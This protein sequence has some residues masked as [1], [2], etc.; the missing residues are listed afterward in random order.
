ML[1]PVP[2][3]GQKSVL[4]QLLPHKPSNTN[5]KRHLNSTCDFYIHV[6]SDVLLFCHPKLDTNQPNL[7]LPGLLS[8][9]NRT[10]AVNIQSPGTQHWCKHWQQTKM[11]TILHFELNV[12]ACIIWCTRHH[13]IIVNE[14]NVSV[15]FMVPH[16]LRLTHHKAHKTLGCCLWQAFTC[17][18]C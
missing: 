4:H 17:E 9:G 11:K 5:I 14:L 18:T 7:G 3:D 12:A 6:W 16:C 15:Y 8:G 13:N 2:L 10:I 1:L